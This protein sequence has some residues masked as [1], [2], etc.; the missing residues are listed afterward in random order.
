MNRNNCIS[1]SR[2]FVAALALSA[3]WGMRAEAAPPVV[4]PP[5]NPVIEIPADAPAHPAPFRLRYALHVG[6]DRKKSPAKSVVAS[7]PTGG[8]LRADASDVSVVTAMGERLPVTVLSHDP[9]GNTIVQFPRR[10]DDAWYYAFAVAGEGTPLPTPVPPEV[11]PA[12]EGLTVEIRK[13][14]GE[15]LGDWALVREGLTSSK[16]VIGNA[17]VPEVVEN[18][19]PVRPNDPRN[20]AASYRGFLNVPTDGTYRF[21]LNAEDAAFLFIDGF[22]VT[23]RVGTNTRMVGAVRLREVGND[24]E[25]KAGVHPLEVHHVM[26]SNPTAI[27]Y[28]ALMWCPPDAKAYAY[29]PYTRFVQADYARVAAVDDAKQAA[30]A[31]FAFGIDDTLRSGD[32]ELVYLVDFAAISP[33]G[34]KATQDP[35]TLTWDFGDGTTG[36][37]SNVSHVYFQAGDYEVTLKSGDL[38]AYRTNVHV[39]P[40]PGNTSPLSLAKTVASLKDSEWQKFDGERLNRM[41]QFLLVCEQPDRWP[42]IDQVAEKLLAEPSLELKQKVFIQRTRME[43][44]AHQGKAEEAV[45]L[46]EKILGEFGRVP[47]LQ[48]GFKLEI[49]QVYHRHWKKFDEAAARYEK[50]VNENRRVEH[51]DVRVA[52][53]RWG[54]LYAETGDLRRA[55]ECYRMANALG[56][57]AFAESSLTGAVTRGGLL[58]MAE[59]R[60]KAGDVGH[61]RQLLER[62][63]MNYPEQK[64]EGLYRVL[65]AD[66]DRRTGRYEE[67]LRNYEILMKLQQWAGFHDRALHG[68]ADTYFRLG[69]FAKAIEWLDSLEKSFPKFYEKQKLADFRKLIGERQ[70]RAGALD[71]NKTVG[72]AE[73]AD[74]VCGFE[75][76]EKDAWGK[77]TGF[78]VGRGLGIVGPH[79]GVGTGYPVYAGYFDMTRPIPALAGGEY[80]VEMWYRDTLMPQP[81]AP[82]IH[83]YLRDEK[84][85]TET[86]YQGTSRIERGF[87]VWRKVGFPMQVPLSA[88]SGDIAFTIRQ[89]AGVFEFDGLT[90]RAV[91]DQ[92]SDSLNN[93]LKGADTE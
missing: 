89:V 67:A 71:A 39:W 87:G 66:A 27:G 12:Q 14:A 82:H 90:V 22:K 59:Q 32:G 40:A 35:N 43:S 17:L 10:G 18:C 69:Q 93:F 55:G 92:Q 73:F 9:A 2:V 25:L 52:A 20:Y 78:Q 44:L 30:A 76:E 41:F 23:E 62:I 47:S 74:I 1:I 57:Q 5:H 49:A 48:V 21:F 7:L 58:R 85:S 75:P 3:W 79:V 51:P 11:K 4:P 77:P 50:I 24:V 42:L 65:R 33:S 53:I 15:E 60:L 31:V 61:T 80:W 45:A 68:L 16:N 54:D 28:C 36:R 84:K 19:N 91:T 8:R 13:W 56:G 46:G 63:E 29:V 37:G 70:A 34:A 38:P 72:A 86:L 88:T 64:L 6:G 81:L 83:M 26:G